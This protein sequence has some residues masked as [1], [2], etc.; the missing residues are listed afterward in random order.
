MGINTKEIASNQL[1]QEVGNCYMVSA[2]ESISHIPMLLSYIFEQKF[3]SNQGNFKV[4]FKQEDGK[5]KFYYILN[6]FPVEDRILKFMKPLEKEAYAIIFEKVWAVIRGGY[7]NLE[8]G[9]GYDVL[10]EV[11]GTKSICLFND[12]MDEFD[13]QPQKYIEDKKLSYNSYDIINSKIQKVKESDNYWKKEILN[14]NDNKIN[15]NKVFKLIKYSEKNDGAIITTS[16]NM[17]DGGHE[18][19][20]LGTYT[21]KNPKLKSTT[22][23]PSFNFSKFIQASVRELFVLDASIILLICFSSFFDIF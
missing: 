7:K 15:S 14:F 19:S 23:S 16:I 4:T 10:N 13:L 8:S 9:R 5:S 17:G 3:S 1:K 20:I 11:L 6:S 2:L 18:Y 21:K 22:M 12:N